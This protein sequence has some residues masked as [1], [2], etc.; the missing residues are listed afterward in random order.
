MNHARKILERTEE[1]EDDFD[2]KGDFL[3]LGVWVS[4]G[5]DGT[6]IVANTPATDK[7]IHP[8]LGFGVPCGNLVHRQPRCEGHEGK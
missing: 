4:Q 8:V 2:D 5:F 1:K 6:D 7:K 3:P